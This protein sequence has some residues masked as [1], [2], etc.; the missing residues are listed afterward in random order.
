MGDHYSR[1][2]YCYLGALDD[3]WWGLGRRRFVESKKTDSYS[4]ERVGN[5]DWIDLWRLWHARYC[6][7]LTPIAHASQSGVR[8]SLARQSAIVLISW[9]IDLILGYAAGWS[10]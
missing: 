5:S 1:L 3:R 8:W 2:A 7:G 9:D 6:P 10:T 4:T